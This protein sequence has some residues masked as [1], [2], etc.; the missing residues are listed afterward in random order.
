MICKTTKGVKVSVKTN[1]Q[2]IFDGDIHIFSYYVILENKS[3]HT[4]K[5]LRRHWIIKDLGDFDSQVKGDGVI[6]KQPIIYPGEI[7]TYESGAKLKSVIG[8]MEGKYTFKRMDNGQLFDVEIPN[9]KL[10]APQ[11]FN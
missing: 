8:S 11:I 7:F 2:G 1:Y 4:I 10:T 6:G 9:F 3:N 5:L